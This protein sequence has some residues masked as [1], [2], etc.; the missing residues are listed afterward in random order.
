MTYHPSLDSKSLLTRLY[1]RLKRKIRKRPHL[2]LLSPSLFVLGVFFVIP[3]IF[4]FIS[5]LQH[6]I[7][8]KGISA[9]FTGE[10]YVKFLTDFYYIC[11]LLMTLLL[12]LVVTLLTLVIGYPLAYF[13]ARTTSKKKG[14]L[15]ALVIFPL[16]LNMVVRSFSWIVLLAN[17]GLLN[18]LLMDFHIIE[19]PLK[20]LYN[21]KGV[22][23]GLTHIFLPFM[24]IALAS[25]IQNIPRDYEEAAQTLG[26]NKLKTF[27]RVT[28]PLSL[29]GIIAGSLL[30]FLLTITAFVTP[31]LL[32]GI[33]VKIMPNIIFQE[34][35]NTFNWPFGAAMGFILLL[36][37]LVII[38]VYLRVFRVK[39]GKESSF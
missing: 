32:G 31:R 18:N 4:L 29:P 20:L 39:G 16:F 23:I 2:L 19:E 34:F 21:Y 22:V 25:V 13:I 36:V 10:N 6:Y 12:G 3:L 11:V 15:V 17:K 7:P 33:T 1:S 27:I 38:S 14:L 37:T 5:S 26:A 9:S 35:M 30:V 8:G 28:L 24:V